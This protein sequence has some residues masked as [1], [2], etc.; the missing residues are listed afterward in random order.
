MPYIKIGS[1]PRLVFAHTFG[2]DEYHGLLSKNSGKIE[3]SYV[4]E[5]VLSVRGGD[6]SEQLFQGDVICNFFLD[7]INVD[8]STYHCHHTVCFRMDFEL[9]EESGEGA[10][11]IAWVTRRESGTETAQRL[12]D[13]IIRTHTVYP[14]QEWRC[15][16]LFLELMEALGRA[17]RKA[18]ASFSHGEYRYVKQAK[19]YLY[20]HI[21]QPILQKE[22]AAHLGITPEYLC[23]VFKRCEGQTLVRYVNTVKLSRI[24]SLMAN[25]R[26]PLHSAAAMYGYSD[27]NYVSRLY[28]KYYGVCITNAIEGKV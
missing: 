21:N 10:V 12:I 19:R 11:E 15:A 4:K 18:Q 6:V 14:E 23:A 13:E 20:E 1:L 3:V 16:G 2:A 27:P 24:R 22:I 28:K 9:T 25:E 17:D 26:I 5:G 8:A 7:D